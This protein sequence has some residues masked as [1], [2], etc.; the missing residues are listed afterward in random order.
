MTLPLY[1]RAAAMASAI[2]VTA[3]IISVIAEIGHPPPDVHLD[4]APAPGVLAEG[5]I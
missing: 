1:K 2:A 5:S 4:I 3:V